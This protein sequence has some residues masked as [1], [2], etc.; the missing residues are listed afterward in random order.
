M[1]E[2]SLNKVKELSK[3]V[4]FLMHDKPEWFVKTAK[5]S[6]QKFFMGDAIY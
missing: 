6:F 5:A 3:G 2:Y 4:F 1:E